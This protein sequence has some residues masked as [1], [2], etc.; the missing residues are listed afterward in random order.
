M[1]EQKHK[2]QP[3]SRSSVAA[4]EQPSIETLKASLRGELLQPDDEGYDAARKVY[5]GM[6]DRH[7]RLIV[8]CAGVADVITAVKY[9]REHHLVTAVR[10]GGHNVVGFAVCDDGVVI[11][12]SLMKG[13]WIDLSSHT[14][15][16]E[17]GL[18]WGEVNRDLQLFGLGAT[19][20]YISSTGVSGLTLGGGFG[21]LVRKHG[22][23]CDNLLSVNVVTADGQ[24]L[25]ASS[26][27]NPDLFWGL[28]GGSGNFGIATSFEFRVFPVGMAL[29]GLL[30]YP[31]D[32]AKEIL[33]F[34][35]DFISTAPEE[36]T[37]GVAFLT[38]PPFPFLAQ[39]V[40]GQ[41][42]FAIFA[43]YAGDLQTGEQVL[44]PLRNFGQPMAD[45]IQ[46][47]P[48]SAVQVMADD[49]FPRGALN[50]WKSNFLTGLDDAAIDTIREYISR[51]PSPLTV[52]IIDHYGNGAV[53][54]VGEREMAFPHRTGDFNIV[55]TSQWTDP[56]DTEKNILWTRE[57]WEAIQPFS[58]YAAYVN[59]IGDEGEDLVKKAYGSN[60][61][62]LAELKKKYDPTNFFRLNQNIKPT[63]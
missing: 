10:G 9:A 52:V 51:V 37:T 28:R 63:R 36:L 26:A 4:L 48:Y 49:L 55:I 27:E 19:G 12:L 13:L 7:P 60:Y 44:R 21:W 47:M 16:V 41:P 3:S 33:Q 43:V 39:Q 11:D 17:A 25:K 31:I 53:Q 22:L 45:L 61:E 42:I 30:L 62:S 14:I 20:G 57:L 35:R 8:R 5:N 23:A 54:R 34:Y 32:Q 1:V 50:Y 58:T 29:S 40:H 18:T 15:R 56:E 24:F 2:G 38:A 6:I 59:Y 46:P